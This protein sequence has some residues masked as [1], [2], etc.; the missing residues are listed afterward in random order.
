MFGR[1]YRYPGY[2]FGGHTELTEAASS[3]YRTFPECSVDGIEAVPNLTD[4]SGPWCVRYPIEH[5]LR[6]MLMVGIIMTFYV[7]II[8]SAVL[9]FRLRV[10]KRISGFA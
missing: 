5:T 1:G 3:S 2:I 9:I 4:N 8:D 6:S 10:I 7:D